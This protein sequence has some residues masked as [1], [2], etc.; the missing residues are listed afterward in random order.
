[1]IC[2]PYSVAYLHIMAKHLGIH[3]CWFHGGKSAHYDIP[4]L[5]IKEIM[6]KCE[7]IS[8]KELLEIIQ[9]SKIF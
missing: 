4:K 5:H 8:S 7:V 2:V 6:G 3:R 9:Y 1:M